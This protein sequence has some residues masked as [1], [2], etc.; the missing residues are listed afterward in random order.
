[1]DDLKLGTLILVGKSSDDVS[2]LPLEHTHIT[3][4]IT[5][6]VAVVNVEQQFANPFKEVI[7]LEYL[8]PLPEK[9]AIVDYE[10]RIGERIIKAQIQE[11]E[12]ARRTYQ[13]AVEQGQRASLLEQRRPNLFSIQIGNVQPN[14]TIITQLTYEDRLHYSDGAYEFVFPMGI[15]PKY[16]TAGTSTA[17]A[18]SVDRPFE[19]IARLIAPADINLSLSTQGIL[20]SPLSPTHD[21]TTISDSDDGYT[22]NLTTTPNKDFRLKWMVSSEELRTASWGSKNTNGET[23]LITLLPPRLSDSLTISPREFIFVLDRSGSMSGGEKSPINQAVNA[24]RACIRALDTSDTFTIIAFDDKLE[25]FSKHPQAVSQANVDAADRWLD[26]IHARGG[27]EI[28]GALNSALDIKA[29]KTR[30]RYVVFLTDGAVSAEDNVYKQ[31]AKKRGNARIFSFGIGSSV[32]RALLVK[33]AELGRGTSEFLGINEDIED[34]LIRFQDRV[35]YPVLHDIELIWENASGWD[36]YPA[37][38]PDI[39]VG[40]PLEITTKL[41]RSGDTKLT[42]NGRL[43]QE[44]V[45]YQ[46]DIPSAETEN[47]TINRLWARAR[48]ESLMDSV[49]DGANREEVRQNIIAL[50]LENRIASEY[51]SFVAVDSEETDTDSETRHVTVSGALPEGLNSD[52]FGSGVSPRYYRMASPPPSASM[53]F[54][55]SLPSAPMMDYMEMEDSDEDGGVLYSLATPMEK[56]EAQSPHYDKPIEDLNLSTPVYNAL[57]RTGI[58]S[59]GDVEDMLNRGADAMLAIRNFGEDSLDELQA[60]MREGG[61]GSD[62]DDNE[63]ISITDRD[64]ILKKYART[65]NVNG[66]WNDSVEMTAAVLLTFTREGHTAR[67]GNYRRQI[68]KALDWLGTNA[69]NIDG[70]MRTILTIVIAEHEGTPLPPA[71]SAPDDIKTLEDLRRVALSHGNASAPKSLIQDDVARAWLAVGKL[72]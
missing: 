70:M 18:E 40:E 34:A 66:S 65:Q 42:I 52:A 29:D 31:I 67:T 37:V 8:F 69:G 44:S 56:A 2:P 35:S 20:E 17:E 26:N 41:A 1:M 24:L 57:K 61:Y 21:K 4:Q 45:S 51:T 16:H 22:I 46:F 33:M 28:V 13:K 25:W 12:T 54:G 6:S 53:T 23:Y 36:T 10:I 62:G 59:V 72:R 7:E 60:K 48:I 49:H 3:G 71:E 58:T 9:A 19:E 55:Y 50:G 32:N 11:K 14:E 15:T 39:Y 38:L 43:G 63:L 47:P 68:K 30:S 5:G 27:T 64:E